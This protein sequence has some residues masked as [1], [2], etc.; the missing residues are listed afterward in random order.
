MVKHAQIT[1]IYKS[2]CFILIQKFVAEIKD[3]K[4]QI[5]RDH[6]VDKKTTVEQPGES[7]VLDRF[8]AK[9]RT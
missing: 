1:I 4:K 3:V 9:R 2:I 6:R 5:I 7:S 8:K